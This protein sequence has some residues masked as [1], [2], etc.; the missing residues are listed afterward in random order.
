MTYFIR[1]ENGEAANVTKETGLSEANRCMMDG[2][3]EVAE[4]TA[5][6]DF[7]DIRYKDGRKV[8]LSRQDGDMPEPAPETIPEP[9]EWRGTHSNF[10]HLHRFNASR[11][12]RCNPR[13]HPSYCADNDKP[14]EFLTK[15]EVQAGEYA[16]LYSFCPRCDT[17]D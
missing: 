5:V 13:F 1:T 8:T 11:R 12:A 7:Y 2:R 10:S 16:D 15:S 9:R 4:M 17:K 14:N 3:R 6:S